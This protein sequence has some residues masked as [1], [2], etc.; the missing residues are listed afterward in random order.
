MDKICTSEVTIWCHSSKTGHEE[1]VQGMSRRFLAYIIARAGFVECIY[2][3]AKFAVI[4]AAWNSHRKHFAHVQS[5]EPK[6]S[7]P[8][9]NKQTCLHCCLYTRSIGD[10][11]N[12]P[13][14]RGNLTLKMLIGLV[15]RNGTTDYVVNIGL[16]KLFFSLWRSFYIQT[17]SCFTI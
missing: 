15:L 8:S 13:P 10:V 17:N 11:H 3:V 6:T 2:G 7:W 5:L 1:S 14:L 12:K 16:S 9:L 4:L